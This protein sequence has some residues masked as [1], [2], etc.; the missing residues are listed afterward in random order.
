MVV[1]DVGLLNIVEIT[2]F[3]Q[4]AHLA[5]ITFINLIFTKIVTQSNKKTKY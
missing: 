2:H 4:V 3:I 1:I 5:P